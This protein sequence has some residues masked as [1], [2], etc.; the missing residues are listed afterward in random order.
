MGESPA[1]SRAQPGAQQIARA[2]SAW[3]PLRPDTRLDRGPSSE[4]EYRLKSYNS[5]SSQ[6]VEVAGG[7]VAMRAIPS[8][9]PPRLRGGVQTDRVLQE[10]FW[11]AQLLNHHSLVKALVTI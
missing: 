2:G 11:V 8:L 7:K 6:Q 9:N 1:G 10:D 3:L 5:C 4:V